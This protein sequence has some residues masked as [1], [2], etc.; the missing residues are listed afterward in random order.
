[1]FVVIR[2]AV[3]SALREFLDALA[4]SVSPN[5]GPTGHSARELVKMRYAV[6]MLI[7]KVNRETG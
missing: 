1:M 3:I 2:G 4:S 5:E 7:N 6:E